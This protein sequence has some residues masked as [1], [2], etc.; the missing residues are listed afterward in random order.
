MIAYDQLA[1]S[2]YAAALALWNACEGV[3][4]NESPAEFARILARNPGL[5]PAARAGGQLVGA[6]FCCHDGRRGYLYHLGVAPAHRGQGV[7]RE[8]V[9]RSL[10]GLKTADIRR[11]SI[12]SIV[13]NDSG[14]QFWLRLG[15]RLRTDLKLLAIDL[16]E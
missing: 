4:A 14:E 6:V 15:W 10:A 3:R 8:L 9:A 7:A 12:H 13:G 5:S 11:C 2:D 1:I 16:P